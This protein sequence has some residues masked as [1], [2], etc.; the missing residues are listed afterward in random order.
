MVINAMSEMGELYREY[1]KANREESKIRRARHR[2]QAPKILAREGIEFSS[3]NDGAHLRLH[4]PKTAI[5][6]WPGTGY[7]RR[8]DTGYSGRG[9][10][11]LIKQ[12]KRGLQES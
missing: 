10:F 1:K 12:Y 6:F 2:E 5:N 8:E 4:L 11:N 7:W 3:H 9:I